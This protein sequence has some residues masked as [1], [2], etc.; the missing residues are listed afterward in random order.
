M[1]ER[2]T[3]APLLARPVRACCAAVL[4]A[5]CLGAPTGAA[6]AGGSIN[7]QSDLPAYGPLNVTQTMAGG[8]SGSLTLGGDNNKFIG[9]CTLS[10][11]IPSGW[12]VLQLSGAALSATPGSGNA[13]RFTWNTDDAHFVDS[14]SFD[15]SGTFVDVSDGFAQQIE[16]ADFV[17]TGTVRSS[18]TGLLIGGT[19]PL[20]DNRGVVEVDAKD[21][22]ELAGT[23]I[24]DT[25]GT[26]RAAGALDIAGSTFEIHGGS[27]ASGVLTSPYR[28][29][30]APTAVTFAAGLPAS[31]HGTIELQVASTLS[32]VVPKG[33][34]L[35]AS[36]SIAAERGSGNAG[37]IE[38]APDS[39]N[40]TFTDSATFR[41][42][43]TFRDLAKGFSQQIQV[44]DF[45]NT[46]L[47]VSHSPGLSLS[48]A[49]NAFDN[50][51]I[52]Q[53]DAKGSFAAGG[54]FVLDRG[55]IIRTAGSFDVA[56]S[57]FEVKGGSVAS[58]ALVSPYHLGVGPTAIV[59]GP[60][61]PASSHGTIKI[62]V[63]SKVSGS[64][65]AT[66]KLVVDGGQITH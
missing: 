48:G 29:G 28:L 64:I 65:P 61:L 26:M 37:T 13:G 40:S 2:T 42:S 22:F 47:V 4:V 43:G 16:V 12:S 52:V 39:G 19:K 18:S 63:P 11:T 10:G 60:H 56:G 15:N 9:T 62:Q 36:S 53:V 55:G 6:S 54:T 44:A 41:N 5:L 34:A 14:G 1:P 23:F 27:V 59:F 3:L 35:A 57:T 31:S 24:L 45:V 20:F 58:G 32:G 46:G 7:C 25:G 21:T 49:A 33:W 30:V 8:S 50:R 38:W 66:W 51:G 17:N